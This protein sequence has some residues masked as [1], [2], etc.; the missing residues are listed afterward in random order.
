MASFAALGRT[1]G[2]FNHRWTATEAIICECSVNNS[3]N[4]DGLRPSSIGKKNEKVITKSFSSFL[5]LGIMR[6][7]GFQIS[8]EEE[9]T[10]FSPTNLEFGGINEQPSI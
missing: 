6:I 1:T 9:L 5:S 10:L 2:G 3:I 7:S 8:F 4:S